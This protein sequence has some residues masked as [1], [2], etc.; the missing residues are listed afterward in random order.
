[1]CVRGVFKTALS[2]PR[3]A[4]QSLDEKW[5]EKLFEKVMNQF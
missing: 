1:M 5:L 2:A 4:L 3:A